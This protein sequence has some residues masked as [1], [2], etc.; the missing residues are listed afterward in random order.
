MMGAIRVLPESVTSQ[1]AAGEVIERPSSIVRELMDNSIDAKSDKID[2]TIEDGGRRSVRVSDNGG[3]MGRDDLLLCLER[4]A[5]SKIHSMQ[6]LFSIMTLGFRGEALPSIASVSRMEI[7]TR[8]PGDLIGHRLK[9]SG[10]KLVSMDEAG[11]P[12]GTIVQVRDLFYNVPVRKKFLRSAR[13]ETDHIIDVFSRIALPFTP[14]HFRLHD[15]TRPILNL[16]GCDAPLDRISAIMGRDVAGAMVETSQSE[17]DIKISAYLA[18]PSLSRSKGDHILTYLNKRNI[19]DRL[20]LRA[21]LEG[22]GQRLMRG[23]YPYAVLFIEMNPLKV[24]INVHPM[25]QEVR[26]HDSH[27]VYEMILQTID[28]ALRGPGVPSREP[29]PYKKDF[30][31]TQEASTFTVAESPQDYP[32]PSS[33]EP[34]YVSW[35]SHEQG[36]IQRGPQII[37]QLKDTYILCQDEDGLLLID[38]HAAHERIVYESLKNAYQSSSLEGQ[39]F[40]IPYKLE[41]PQKDARILEKKMDDLKVLGVELDHF[42]GSTFIVRSVPSLLA[43]VQWEAF[44]LD[45]IPLLEGE[46]DLTSDKVMDRILTTMACHGSLRAGKSMTH[47]EMTHLLHQL[48]A[49]TL[50]TH[51]PHGRPVYQKIRFYDIEKMFKRIV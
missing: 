36:L 15:G 20:I 1:I 43:G 46:S 38:Q 30:P 33:R 27:R 49:L 7:V 16:P 44:V 5:T 6:D 48:E 22:Y 19:R 34:T 37:G 17:G 41:I 23:R 28:K 3:G 29:P 25:K 14:I 42:G 8:P 2:I 11:A 24:D 39:R 21:L 4:Y 35:K 47:Q 12:S 31:G 45:L 40:L 18:P 13:T 50:S 10:G 9:V 26:F 51:C 32:G